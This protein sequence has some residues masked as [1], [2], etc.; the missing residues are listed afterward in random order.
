MTA[1]LPGHKCLPIIQAKS[2]KTN[3]CIKQLSLE[4]HPSAPHAELQRQWCFILAPR[5][6]QDAACPGYHAYR[7]QHELNSGH[8]LFEATTK[9]GL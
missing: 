2:Q 7:S 9:A 6:G 1:R 4:L 3:G 5:M 8:S